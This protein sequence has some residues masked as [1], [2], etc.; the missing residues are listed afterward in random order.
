MGR[1][2]KGDSWLKWTLVESAWSH[3]HFCPECHLAEVF[4]DACKRKGNSCDAIKIVARK[5]VNVVWA[6]WTYEKEFTVK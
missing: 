5:L 3:I 2:T 4:R 1:E 6:V